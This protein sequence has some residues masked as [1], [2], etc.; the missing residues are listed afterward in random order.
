MSDFF[1]PANYI[2]PIAGGLPVRSLEQAT[3]QPIASPL[4]LGNPNLPPVDPQYQEHLTSLTNK[5]RELS[6]FVAQLPP[7][8]RQSLINYDARRVSQGA[9]PLTRRQTLLAGQTAATGEPA[10]PEPERNPL[11]LFG[12]FRSDLSTIL[13]SIPRLPMAAFNEVRELGQFGQQMQE[14]RESGA[15][16]LQA[17]LQAPGVRLLPG[18]YVA[19]NLA[20]GQEGVRE[21]ISHPLFSALDVLPIANRAAGA[22]RTGRAL[23]EAAEQA[24]RR[25]RPLTGMLTNR[26]REGELQRTRVG[27]AVD[28]VRDETPFGQTLD[29]AFGGRARDA[30][31][32]EGRYQTRLRMFQQGIGDPQLRSE[33]LLKRVQPMFERHAETYPQLLDNS[34]EGQAF[35]Q[36]MTQDFTRGNVEGYDPAFVG[37]YRQMVDDLGAEAVEQ[38]VLGQFEGEFYPTEVARRLRARE[39][40]VA[41]AREMQG[42]R[43]E[44]LNPSGQ[45]TPTDMA[46]TLGRIQQMDGY[47]A[48]LR[49]ARGL[50]HTVDAY[51]GRIDGIKSAIGQAGKQRSGWA[52]VPRQFEIAFQEMID[53]GVTP[54]RSATEIVDE[55][56]RIRNDRQATR[57]EDAIRY[58]ERGA[59]SEALKNLSNRKPPRFPEDQWPRFAEDAKSAARRKDFDETTGSKATDARIAQQQRILDRAIANNPPARFHQVLTDKLEGRLTEEATH[60]L[61][62]NLGADEAARLTTAIQEKRWGSVFPD[63]PVEE[64]AAFLRGIENEVAATWRE[65]QQAGA[66]PLFVHKV[67]PQRAQAAAMG[68]IGPVPKK[69]TQGKERALDL[70]DG[71]GDLQVALTHQAS[72]LLQQTYREKYVSELVESV[73]QREDLLREE[74]AEHARFRASNDPAVGFEGHLKDIMERRYEKF[75]PDTRGYSWGGVNLDK[76]RQENWYIPKAI[77]ENLHRVTKPPSMVARTLEPITNVFR[78]NVIGM[79]PSVVVNNF[80]ANS[81]AM[82][83]ETGPGPLRYWGKAREWLKDPMSIPDD[84]MRAMI[85]AENPSMPTLNRG[86]FLRSQNGQKFLMGNRAGRMFRESAVM[87]GARRGK[88]ALDSLVEKNLNLQRLGD[89][90]YRG[91]TYMH[92]Y[93]RLLKAGKSAEQA[94][95]GAVEQVRRVIVDYTAFTPIERQAIR[96]IIPFYSYMGHAMRF[97]GRY[98]LDHPLRISIASKFAELERERLGA[99]PDRFLSMLPIFDVDENGKQTM[100]PLRPFDPFGDIS[101]MFAM[102]GWLSSVN[103]VIATAL[104]QAGVRRGEAEL[105]PE[106]RYDPETGRMRPVHPNF[107]T[108]VI[109]NVAPRAGLLTTA[110]GLNQTQAE[111]RGRDEGAANRQLLSMAGIPQLWREVDVPLEGIR[112]EMSRQRSER[113]VRNQAL[114]SGNWQEAMR[115]PSLRGYYDQ[116]TQ[117]EAAQIA[118]LTPEEP[119]IVADRLGQHL[120]I[121]S[122]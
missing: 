53:N 44:Y 78:Y 103:P 111:V 115:Y 11:D 89:N 42:L 121:G 13:K 96:T 25:P 80:F 72:E 119:Q 91:M 122:R 20:G 23:T 81:V 38:G 29:A 58:G 110:L 9:P 100:I 61:G 51:G 117:L 32:L 17:L 101:D 93:D 7:P 113:D 56:R 19:G 57:L 45:M 15:S 65:L 49:T 107:L 47:A 59:A 26:F 94:A 39:G 104:E 90:I 55:L 83:A 120:G 74:L 30:A 86:K 82:M 108:S 22:T 4:G 84:N 116:V 67:T 79:S 71:V 77:A 64:R 68:S 21:T 36:Q 92:E 112:A 31:R 43:N 73:G 3:P 85:T 2:N 102:S 37:D 14:A 66:D 98:P 10:T 41:A 87:D 33:E 99:L 75:D 62:R 118:D 1:D 70:S 46:E 12:N 8:V 106:L 24:G 105:Y 50:M 35:R 18:A 63:M 52:E 114:R 76:Y 88:S 28:M 97:I 54:R 60:V 16:G 34:A 95:A 48:R 109:E 69:P 6:P 27:E 40:N 5:Y